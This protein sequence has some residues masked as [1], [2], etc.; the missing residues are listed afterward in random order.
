[1]SFDAD[2]LLHLGLHALQH[3]DTEAALHHLKACLALEED[4]A[5]ACYLL[6]STYAEIRLYDRARP[7][8]RRTLELA[9]GEHTAAF[10]LGL[11]ELLGGD[12][13]SAVA[14]WES[15]DA[16]R[17]DHHL[18]LFKSGLLALA[19]GEADRGAALIDAGIRGNADN[20][21]L[22]ANMQILRDAGAARPAASVDGAPAAPALDYV[23]SRY[24]NPYPG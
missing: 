24:Q 4:N 17:E 2:E 5:A 8:F 15:L 21:A 6:A 1:M 16:L 18:R 10:Q 14:A 12:I 13:E 20:P 9:P 23:L 3:G 22:N 7:L 19:A 11:L